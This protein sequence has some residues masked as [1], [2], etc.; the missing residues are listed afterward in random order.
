MT[1]LEK[2]DAGLRDALSPVTWLCIADVTDGHA[3]EGFKDGRA[4][5][6]SGLE[7]LILI[8]STQFEGKTLLRRQQMVYSVLDDD[9]SNGIL[10]S[11]RMKCLTPKQ[12]EKK[13]K[14]ISLRDNVPCASSS[15]SSSPFSEKQEDTSS[16]LSS[17]KKREIDSSFSLPTT[18][19]SKKRGIVPSSTSSSST[20]RE[21]IP[22]S[23][24][25]LS[26]KK[27]YFDDVQQHT[28]PPSSRAIRV[29]TPQ[30]FPC[31]CGGSYL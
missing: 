29:V 25:P 21:N 14:P 10:H 12:W 18:S 3:V 9:L 24:S 23:S 20:K 17:S 11:V 1:V 13:G 28:P 22:Y 7:A 31:E 6:P 27:R 26:S 2:H 30:N 16:L 4:L 8:V 5:D 15:T 19:S